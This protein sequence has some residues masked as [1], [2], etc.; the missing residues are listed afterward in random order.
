MESCVSIQL[1][2]WM[3]KAKRQNKITKCRSPIAKVGASLEKSEAEKAAIEKELKA[4]KKAHTREKAA[5][6]DELE[7]LKAAP[8]QRRSSFRRANC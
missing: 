5:L 6:M 3:V 8:V 4:A 1:Y 7:A 2:A